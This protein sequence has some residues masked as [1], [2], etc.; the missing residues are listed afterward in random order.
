MKRHSSGRI[1]ALSGLTSVKFSG[2][3]GRYRVE[4][5][6]IA[7]QSGTILAQRTCPCRCIGRQVLKVF[8]ND[9]SWYSSMEH[10]MQHNIITECSLCYIRL[11]MVKFYIV[12][13]CD[14]FCMLDKRHSSTDQEFLSVILGC[15]EQPQWW[16]HQYEMSGHCK[17]C[18]G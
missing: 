3:Y 15:L 10:T 6:L 9:F 1:R 5:V 14:T 7:P 12:I 16:W 2:A 8:H 18:S 17:S 11:T 13:D 4:R